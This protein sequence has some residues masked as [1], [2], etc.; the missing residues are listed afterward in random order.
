MNNN[1]TARNLDAQI[2]SLS[3]TINQ[4]PSTELWHQEISAMPEW[5]GADLK[6]TSGYVP[7]KERSFF[8]SQLLVIHTRHARQLTWLL[9]ELRDA[10]SEQLDYLNKYEFYGNLGETAQRH[11][12]GEPE[13][14]AHRPL[15]H[16][17]LAAAYISIPEFT[18]KER[19]GSS[20]SVPGSIG[21]V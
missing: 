6:I 2:M 11:L 7:Q 18:D 1:F 12:A 16:A 20:S 4:K 21:S 10:F 14:A 8:D 5:Y 9:L 15:L 19:S 17:V 3:Q 13:T